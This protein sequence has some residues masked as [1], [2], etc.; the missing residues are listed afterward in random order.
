MLNKAQRLR[1]Y[2]QAARNAGY[3][4]Q[5]AITGGRDMEVWCDWALEQANR[6][7]PSVASPP[8]VLDYKRHFYWH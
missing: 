6:L 7:D 5:S 1:A 8:S 4:A 3:Y 2:V